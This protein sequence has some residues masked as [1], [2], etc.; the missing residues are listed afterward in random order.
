MYVGQFAALQEGT[1][2]LEL[3]VPDSDEEV[4]TRRIQVRVPDVERESP[5]RNDSLLSELASRTGGTYYVG[6]DAV[7][8][9]RGL[10]PLAT[11]LKDRTETTYLAGVTD[12]DFD[13]RWMRG[14]LIAVCGVL[15]LEWLIRRLS[16]LA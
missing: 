3:P 7:L 12:R 13:F 2:R 4:L 9:S 8:G 14:L 15:C 10:P 6:A 11:R 5:Q 16:K 1:Y